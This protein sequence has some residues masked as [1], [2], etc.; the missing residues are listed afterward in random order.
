MNEI[1]ER[2]SNYSCFQKIEQRIVTLTCRPQ[3]GYYLHMLTGYSLAAANDLPPMGE[4]KI[5]E[6]RVT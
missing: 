3:N 1:V 2:Y 6:I 4:L 5:K